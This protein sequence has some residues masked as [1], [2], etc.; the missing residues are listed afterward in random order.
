MPAKSTGDRAI[1]WLLGG[2]PSIRWQ[3]LRDLAGAGETAVERERK[4]VAR[5]GWGGRLLAKQD[6]AG[7]W[8]SKGSSDGGLYSP[9]WKSTTY[10]M[11]LLRDF[12]LASDNRQAKKACRLL[13]E[14]GLQRDGGVNYGLW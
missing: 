10:T 3:A 7:T 8:A 12:G 13:L 6:A 14:G 1:D 2:D 11:M 4:K 5:E 9:K